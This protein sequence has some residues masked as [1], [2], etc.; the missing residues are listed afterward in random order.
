MA[1]HCS[2][3][4]TLG[5][6]AL[7]L[8]NRIRTWYNWQA[9]WDKLAFCTSH[10]LTLLRMSLGSLA[11][12]MRLDPEQMLRRSGVAPHS[13][14]AHLLC[15]RLGR[16]PFEAHRRFSLTRKTNGAR[17]FGKVALSWCALFIHFFR[18]LRAD[19]LAD[20]M[21]FTA[22]QVQCTREALCS[23]RELSVSNWPADGCNRSLR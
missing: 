13:R 6:G 1:P 16:A 2:N 8:C 17:R 23:T 10:H 15:L 9:T 22:Q 4:L 14:Y 5:G 12:S 11:A 20:L 18:L 3:V 21:R 19:G 7:S